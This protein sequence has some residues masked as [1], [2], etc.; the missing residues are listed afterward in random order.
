LL[1]G[2][3]LNY[4]LIDLFADARGDEVKQECQSVT[5]TA[6][7]IARQIPFTHYVFEKKAPHPWAKLCAHLQA[8]RSNAA[9]VRAELCK[10]GQT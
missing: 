8:E 4:K 2:D 7:C 1:S 3:V 6:L 5:V 10:V 9:R